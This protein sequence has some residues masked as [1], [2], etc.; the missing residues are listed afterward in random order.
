MVIAIVGSRTWVEDGRIAQIVSLIQRKHPDALIISGGAR[1]VDT[2]AIRVAKRLGLS[3]KVYP[4]DWDKHGKRAGFL[5]N[6]TLVS[7]ADVVIAF[8]DGESRGT[9][10]SIELA[11][12]AGKPCYIYKP[13]S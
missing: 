12:N 13:R 9:A 10:H 11:E 3:T 7:E 1:G 5:R 6:Q 4:A 8:W 2:I